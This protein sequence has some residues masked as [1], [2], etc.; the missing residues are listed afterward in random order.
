MKVYNFFF[1][2]YIAS[3]RKLA[4]NKKKSF[5]F[6][7]PIL[8][9]PKFINPCECQSISIN[10]LDVIH[11]SIPMKFDKASTNLLLI[12]STDSDD[13]QLWLSVKS[14]RSPMGDC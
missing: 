8:I 9:N 2:N 11:A 10:R 7:S 4:K 3:V 13:A 6:K 12:N 14:M 5:D 1:Y